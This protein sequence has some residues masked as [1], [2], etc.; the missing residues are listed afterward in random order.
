MRSTTTCERCHRSP[1]RLDP[2]MGVCSR[3]FDAVMDT[4]SDW[5]AE[6]KADE[7]AREMELEAERAE[8]EEYALYDED[9]H[10]RFVD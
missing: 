6:C 8:L 4:L 10:V 9:V 3:C 1:V 2:D 5:E 7:F